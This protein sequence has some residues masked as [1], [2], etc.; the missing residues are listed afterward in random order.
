MTPG[1]LAMI[2]SHTWP[3]NVREIQNC[4]TRLAIT[5]Q[6]SEKI[7]QDLVAG[8]MG[9]NVKPVGRDQHIPETW[10]EMDTLRTEA[11]HQVAR[12]IERTFLEHLLRKFQGN[13]TKAAEHIGINRNNFHKLMRKCGV[14][15]HTYKSNERS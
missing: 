3:G 7:D 13:V 12:E 15:A 11:M 8:I 10:E 14:R 9:E 6:K 4:V 5:S 2:Q 1:A